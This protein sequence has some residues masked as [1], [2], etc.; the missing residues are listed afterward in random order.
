VAPDAV[1]REQR[2]VAKAV[3]FGVIYGQGAFGLARQLKIGRQVAQAYIELYFARHP[4]VKAYMERVI[5]EAMDS[6]V[7]TTILGRRRP[8]RDLRSR[9]PNLRAAAER[10]ARNTPI[11]G[12][13]ADIIKLAMLR[14]QARLERDFPA[15]RMLLTVH[16]ELVFEVPTEGAAALAEAVRQEMSAAYALS[17]P[18]VVDVGQGEDWLAAH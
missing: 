2:R 8:L 13:A 11:Q 1:D 9:N 16:D 5:E 7:A 18:L 17:V 14:C 6:G 12:S 3:N 10:M 15:A 4:G